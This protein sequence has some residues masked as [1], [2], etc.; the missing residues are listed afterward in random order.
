MHGSWCFDRTIALYDM[1]AAAAAAQW[2]RLAG[3][4]YSIYGLAL[5][6]CT[7]L[8]SMVVVVVVVKK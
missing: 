5:D 3:G 6:G 4:W 7:G 8:C 1:E 2:I